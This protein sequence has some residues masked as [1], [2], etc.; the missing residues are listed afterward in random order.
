[1]GEESGGRREKC[2]SRS[3]IVSGS[4]LLTCWT[5][6]DQRETKDRQTRFRDGDSRDFRTSKGTGGGLG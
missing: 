2:G 6:R 3:A 1:M 5:G 4:N